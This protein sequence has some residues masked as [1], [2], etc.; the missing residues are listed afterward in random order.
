MAL[1]RGVE[2]TPT[3]SPNLGSGISQMNSG[4]ANTTANSTDGSMA[5]AS[6]AALRGLLDAATNTS[7]PCTTECNPWLT[8][9]AC[10]CDATTMAAMAKCGTCFNLTT[11]VSTYALMCT[12]MV[13]NVTRVVTTTA[14]TAT[15]VINAQS[16][17]AAATTSKASAA[18]SLGISSTAQGAAVA[19]LAS[20]MT[21]SELA[22]ECVIDLP[23]HPHALTVPRTSKSENPTSGDAEISDAFDQSAFDQA[24]PRSLEIFHAFD[25][26]GTTRSPRTSTTDSTGCEVYDCG[27]VLSLLSAARRELQNPGMLSSSKQ[28]EEAKRESTAIARSK[29][30]PPGV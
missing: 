12:T 2:A 8:D 17:S 26:H 15:G 6:D 25:F 20:C 1:N 13:D 7:S 14:P 11:N 19:L 28:Q 30:S 3:A 16:A 29:Q 9:T 21:S 5:A 4:S 23:S 18:N 24:L 22:G 27:A 10:S